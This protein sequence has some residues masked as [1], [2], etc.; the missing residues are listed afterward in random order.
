MI[1]ISNLDLS[2]ANGSC[3]QVVIHFTW[4]TNR[5]YKSRGVLI[6]RIFLLRKCQC[7]ECYARWLN[8]IPTT[9]RLL[10]LRT[11]PTPK[12]TVQDGTVT[13]PELTSTI[14]GCITRKI[15]RLRPPLPNLLRTRSSESTFFYSTDK[16]QGQTFSSPELSLLCQKRHCFSRSV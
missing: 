4:V 11:P 13:N 3:R 6:C 14:P 15:R 7:G 5:I 12:T 2:V 9:R 1:L 16:W 8:D 10:V